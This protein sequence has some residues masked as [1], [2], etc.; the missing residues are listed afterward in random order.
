M[1]VRFGDAVGIAWHGVDMDDR[2]GLHEVLGR[3]NLV[4]TRR[5]ALACGL[6]QDAIHRQIRPGGRWQR[7]LPGVY[8]AVTGTPTQDQRDTAALLYAGPGGTLTGAAALRRHGMRVLPSDPI[9]VLIPAKRVR[10][11]RG[12]VVIHQTTMLPENVCYVGPV[13][14]ALPARAVADAVRG[15]RDLRT[16]RAVVAAAVQGRQCT[17]EQLRA[18]LQ[19]GPMRW[20]ALFRAA[21]AEVALGTRSAPEAELLDLI[22]RGRLPLPLFNPRLYAG[23]E[24]L[25]RPDAW[26][27]DMAVAVE[28]DSKEWHLSP[29]SWER[30]MRR[31]DRMTAVGILV[32]HF[33]PRQI[34]EEPDQVIATIRAALD[35]RRCAAIPAIKTLPAN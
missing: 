32:L 15:V 24:L 35:N 7:L 31:H 6:S 25:A 33:T 9:D 21:L 8:L 27:Q 30:T 29:D 18:E 2:S 34:R 20:S 14:Y 22:R 4:I 19:S 23:K 11:S 13:Q 16:A 12:F 26:W 1:L 28:V 10:Q 3:Q 5:Q 17:I